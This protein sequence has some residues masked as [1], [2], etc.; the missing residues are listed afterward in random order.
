[1]EGDII[2]MQE[3]FRYRRRGITEQGEVVGDFEATG[4]RPL[5]MERLHVAGI[6]L[7]ANMFLSE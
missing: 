5:F 2:S 4:V 6:D 3:I 7:P 1:M